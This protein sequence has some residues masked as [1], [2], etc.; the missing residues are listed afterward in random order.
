MAPVGNVAEVLFGPGTLYVAPIGTTELT[1]ASAAV[2]TAWREV[3]WTDAGSAIDIA[4]TNS[5]VNVEEEFYP[6]LYK[7]TA[8]EMTLGFSMKQASRENL[9][10]ALNVGANAANDAT[11]LQPPAPGDEVR[12]AIMLDTDDGARWIFRKCF[13]SGSLKIDRKKAPNAAL[14]P[15]QFRLEKPAGA[16]PWV[17]FPNADGVI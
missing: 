16:E 5:A 17:V 14:L 3:G 2:P 9:A 10:L 6:V 15:V 8:V 13:Q 7:T 1:S 12:V 11:S 4:Y